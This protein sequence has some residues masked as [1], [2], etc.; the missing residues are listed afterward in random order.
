MIGCGSPVALQFRFT[1]ELNIDR[2]LEGDLDV[3]RGR[4]TTTNMVFFSTFPKRLFAEQV[5]T[6]ESSLRTCEICNVPLLHLTL[7]RGKS[8]DNFPRLQRGTKYTN[9]NRKKAFGAI[10]LITIIATFCW[11]FRVFV[12]N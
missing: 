4:D 1:V 6:S 2:I 11:T 3:N 7:L 5:Y 12:A 10:R 8:R 9:T